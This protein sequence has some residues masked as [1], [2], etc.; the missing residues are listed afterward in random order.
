MLLLLESLPSAATRAAA[1]HARLRQQHCQAVQLLLRH[2]AQAHSS[3]RRAAESHQALH[4]GARFE[5]RHAASR[6]LLLHAMRMVCGAQSPHSA[7]LWCV[8]QVRKQPTGQ[9]QVCMS[10][11]RYSRCASTIAAALRCAL[12]KAST[13]K[14]RRGLQRPLDGT[15]QCRC[16]MCTARHGRATSQAEIDAEEHWP[17]APPHKDSHGT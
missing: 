6:Q 2:A 5:L 1:P 3:S 15:R 13:L 16:I 8:D 12:W 14:L 7:R 4:Q 9:L 11:P 17:R 10:T